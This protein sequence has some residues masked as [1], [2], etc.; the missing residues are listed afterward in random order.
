M[1]LF[2]FFS[3]FILFHTHDCCI[4]Y[5]SSRFYTA[6]ASLNISSGPQISCDEEILFADNIY[7]AA[8]AAAAACLSDFAN[9]PV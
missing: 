7:A 8:A 1:H 9:S 2:S 4:K 3:Q 5:K 6:T